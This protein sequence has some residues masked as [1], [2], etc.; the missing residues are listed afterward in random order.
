MFNGNVSVIQ[1]AADLAHHK[2][3]SQREG[4]AL[5]YLHNA[6]SRAQIWQG[7]EPVD[8]LFTNSPFYHIVQ[9]YLATHIN[10]LPVGSDF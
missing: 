5:N 9:K 6:E 1:T 10:S 2:V 7:K 8:F 3:S 4:C